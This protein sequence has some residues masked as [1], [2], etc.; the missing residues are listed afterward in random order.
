MKKLL[1]LLAVSI[2]SISL[3]STAV[4]A[5]EKE[6]VVTGTISYLVPTDI[7]MLDEYISNQMYSG[8]DAYTGWDIKL[9]SFYRRQDRLSW[10]LYFNCLT[11][12]SQTDV[13]DDLLSNPANSQLLTYDGYNVGYGTYY[14]WNFGN[15]L[16]VKTGGMFDMYGAM[17]K[18]TPDGL[19]NYLNMEGQIMLKAQAAIKYGWDFEKWALDIH[20]RLSLPLAGII[21][22][23]HPSEPAVTIFGND[24]NVMNPAYN[25]IFLASYHNYMSVDYDMGIDFVL[26][27][28]TLTL[29][30]ASTNKW[31]NV[32]DIQNIR[33]IGYMTLG[34]SFDIAP[35]SKF[36]SSNKN[37]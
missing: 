16:K 26:R 23:D 4:S 13:N 31:W 33:K 7:Q 30:F 6:R 22:A 21:S 5:Q 29:G 32:Y 24:H 9:S 34:V 15:K 8:S 27:P 19:N 2:V 37:F 10:D 14:H 28:C 1:F 12:S 17:K 3:S 25:H 20:A 18:S 36:K 11:R 35:R